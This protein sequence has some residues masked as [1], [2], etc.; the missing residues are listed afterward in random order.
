LA[1]LL[2]RLGWHVAARRTG[3]VDTGRAGRLGHRRRHLLVLAR[4]GHAA[5]AVEVVAHGGLVGL[6]GGLLL[7]LAFLALLQVLVRT[8]ARAT[9][10]ATTARCGDGL[11]RLLRRRRRLGDRLL[12][13]AAV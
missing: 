6:L 8:R 7:G 9:R 12:V 13:R 11:F 2:L 10:A 4:L 3:G 5:I 1:L